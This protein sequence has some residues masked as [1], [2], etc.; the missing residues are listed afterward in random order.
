MLQ[1]KHFYKQVHQLIYQCFL[2]LNEEKQQIDQITVDNKLKHS[3]VY[4]DVGAEN[5]LNRVIETLPSDTNFLS[6]TT[7]VRLDDKMN[8]MGSMTFFKLPIVSHAYNADIIDLEE[9]KYPIFYQNYENTNFYSTTYNVE[10]PEG[11]KFIE[12]AENKEFSYQN[13]S[14]KITFKSL[15]ENKLQVKI[16]ATTDF[17]DI[18]TEEYKGFKEYIEKVLKAKDILIGFKKS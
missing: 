1:P 3:K 13:H 18:T 8:E 7:K 17:K 4:Q 15:A 12:I 10:I 9:R 16:I 5:Y 2:D 6:Y 14:Y 11:K